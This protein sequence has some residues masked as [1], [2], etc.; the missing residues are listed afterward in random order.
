MCDHYGE[1]C[2]QGLTPIRS[3]FYLWGWHTWSKQFLKLSPYHS[4]FSFQVK[5]ICIF[6]IRAFVFLLLYLLIYNCLV[7]KTRIFSFASWPFGFSEAA[8][9][10]VAVVGSRNVL[11]SLS[12]LGWGPGSRLLPECVTGRGHPCAVGPAML[13]AEPAVS[14]RDGAESGHFCVKNGGTS[15]HLSGWAGACQVKDWIP[16]SEAQKDNPEGVRNWTAQRPPAEFI[17]KQALLLSLPG[18]PPSRCLKEGVQGW[19]MLSEGGWVRKQTKPWP[20]IHRAVWKEIGRKHHPLLA[21]FSSSSPISFALSPTKPGLSWEY[22]PAQ[23]QSRSQGLWYSDQGW[24]A[25][26]SDSS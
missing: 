7:W 24:L 19:F 9:E 1:R 13:C 23:P 10:S 12:P 2:W 15:S 8:S 25:S 21:F 20:A 6:I 16:K 3:C 5:Y 22:P 26:F 14:V 18:C 4:S 11:G 17:P